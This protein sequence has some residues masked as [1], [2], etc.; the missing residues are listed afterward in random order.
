MCDEANKYFPRI[1]DFKLKHAFK[2]E[3]NVKRKRNQEIETFNGRK[4]I[5]ENV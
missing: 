3:D 4:K 5:N 2:I 1:I